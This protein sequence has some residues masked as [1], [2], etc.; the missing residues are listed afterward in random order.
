[1]FPLVGAPNLPFVT[2]GVRQETL[3]LGGIGQH[4]DAPTPQVGLAGGFLGQGDALPQERRQERGQQAQNGDDHQQF[5][6][7]E[8][9]QTAGPMDGTRHGRNIGN[10]AAKSILLYPIGYNGGGRRRRAESF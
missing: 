8:A 10:P 4:P 9:R 7:A 5:D 3:V 1:M 2:V 6:Q